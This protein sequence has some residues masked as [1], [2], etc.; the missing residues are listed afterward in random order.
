MK[1]TRDAVVII[2]EAQGDETAPITLELLALAREIQLAQPCKI[3]FLMVGHGTEATARDLARRTGREV[4]AVEAETLRDYNTETCLEILQEHLPG[5]SPR[6]VLMGQTPRGMDLAPRLA[7]RLGAGCIT[8]V[9]ALCVEEGELRFSRTAFGGKISLQMAPAR[10]ITVVTATPG[11]FTAPQES[12]SSQGS[13]RLVSSARRSAR[14]RTLGII[15]APRQE[16]GLSEA[17]VIVAAGRGIGTRENLALIER[18]ASVFPRSA[19][20]AS[21]PLCDQGWMDYPRQV[22]L[23][24]ATV[25]PKL[26]FA[27][28]ISGAVQHTVG[29]QGSGFIVAVSRDPHAAI[30]RIADVCVVDDLEAFIPA[31]LAL[32]REE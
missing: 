28:G 20:A 15:E 10:S 1:K 29:M 31:F 5:L 25:S 32:C 16:R 6:F 7:V 22:G 23:T 17:D 3:R 2:A 11:A 24:G 9:D 30:F 13:V 19:V 14:S 4:V 12:V 27:C 8:G 18:L 26:Y 21:R